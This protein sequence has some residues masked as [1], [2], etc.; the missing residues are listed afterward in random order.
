MVNFNLTFFV[1]PIQSL[2]AGPTA[3][4]IAGNKPENKV[5]NRFQNTK[6]CK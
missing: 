4:W 1:S 5:K 6:A 3:E 2:P